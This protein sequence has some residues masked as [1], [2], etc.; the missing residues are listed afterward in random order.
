MSRV[1]FTCELSE[2][3]QYAIVVDKYEVASLCIREALLGTGDIRLCV[4][5]GLLL[6]DGVGVWMYRNTPVMR[7]AAVW[8]E[9]VDGSETA[10]APNW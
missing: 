5:Y 1:M 8:Y 3:L 2:S 10:E 9:V 7:A 4:H 6:C